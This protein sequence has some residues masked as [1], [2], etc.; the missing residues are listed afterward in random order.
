MVEV[1]RELET[2]RGVVDVE[3]VVVV[4]GLFAEEGRAEW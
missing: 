2:W 3:R 1:E 4:V